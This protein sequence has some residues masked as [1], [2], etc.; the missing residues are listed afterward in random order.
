MQRSTPPTTS[1][2][3]LCACKKMC[4]YSWSEQHYVINT[5][6]QHTLILYICRSCLWY[7]GYVLPFGFVGIRYLIILYRL[8]LWLPFQRSIAKI[9]SSVLKLQ[10]PAHSN[11][12]LGPHVVKMQFAEWFCIWTPKCQFEP[13][14]VLLKVFSI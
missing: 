5:T 12:D 14:L 10:I 2:F 7:F 13:V 11:L 9:L 1:M 3:L 6:S 4:I 8:F